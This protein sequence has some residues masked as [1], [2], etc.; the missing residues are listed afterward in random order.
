MLDGKVPVGY[1]TGDDEGGNEMLTERQMNPQP[2]DAVIGSGHTIAIESV[3][4][5]R[6]S[7]LRA[8]ESK[9]EVGTFDDT[10]DEWLRML[11]NT[12]TKYPDTIYIPAEDQ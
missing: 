7:W 4:N 5:G 10:I 2:G 9:D 8:V 6:V 12:L 11:D 1:D 3:E